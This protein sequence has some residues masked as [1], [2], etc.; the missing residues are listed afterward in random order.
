MDWEAFLNPSGG[1]KMTKHTA[2][3]RPWRLSLV[4]GMLPFAITGILLF[5]LSPCWGSEMTVRDDVVVF[6]TERMLAEV[7]EGVITRIFNKL[8]GTEYLVTSAS[9]VP[10]THAT[11][12]VYLKSG[13]SRE[14][15]TPNTVGPTPTLQGTHMLVPDVLRAE[16]LP[17]IERTQKG[18][19]A[20]EFTF[21]GDEQDS[22]YSVR[23]ELDEQ[24]GHLLVTQHGQGSRKALSAV[25][26]S[27]GPVTCRGNLLLPV[28]HGVKASHSEDFFKFESSRW[29]WPSGWPIPVALFNDPLGGLWVH[30]RDTQHRF[31]SIDYRYEGDGAWTI[32]LDSANFAPFEPYSSVDGLTWRIE[33]YEGDWT[34]PVDAYKDWAYDAYDLPGKA[35]ARPDWVDDLKLAIKKSDFVAEDKIEAYLDLLS[36]YV[37]PS[38]T[39]L[40]NVSRPKFIRE[41]RKRGFRTM[42]YVLYFG[43]WTFHDRFKEFEPYSIRNPYSQEVEGWNLKGEWSAE[44]DIKLHYINPAYKPFRDMKIN[45]FKEMMEAAPADGIF[46]DQ[47]FMM[48]NDG[49]GLI[50]GKSTVDGNMAYHKELAAAIPGVAIGG[51]GINEVSFLYE[52]VC[53]F[54]ILSLD[55]QADSTGRA[56]GWSI[57]PTAHERMVPIMPRFLMPHTQPIGYHV[58]N[59]EGPYYAGWR[60]AL[61]IYGAMP[62]MGSPTIAMLGDSESETRRVI[63]RAFAKK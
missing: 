3:K 13:T 7:G 43:L 49:N 33:T 4:E 6:E 41:A 35:Y 8:T 21:R 12:L 17:R 20:V 55:L 45:E 54:H 11:G 1:V 50:D 51:E 46:I 63:G 22:I 29:D 32:A 23:Y 57:Q 59:P 62:T 60:D 52:S 15:E 42:Y 14:G 44:S 40:L 2:V 58:G 5:S 61:H 38:Q 28:F 19:R 56:K 16:K 30:T 48:Y 39:L 24:T 31:K 37:N 26:L 27:L 9:E 25:R 47:S 34:V 53:E 10:S 18:K 36:E